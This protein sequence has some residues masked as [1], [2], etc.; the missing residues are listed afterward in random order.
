M[1]ERECRQ[2]RISSYLNCSLAVP[3]PVAFRGCFD[4]TGL[5]SHV[6]FRRVRH[7]RLRDLESAQFS[8]ADA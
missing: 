8:G 2:L 5:A 3:L 7:N 6:G 4:K 1:I